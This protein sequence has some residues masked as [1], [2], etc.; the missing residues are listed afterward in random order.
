[1]VVLAC[2]G[3]QPRVSVPSVLLR[4]LLVFPP[5]FSITAFWSPANSFGV[6][7]SLLVLDA[8]RG[9]LLE[10]DFF[11]FLIS[12][13]GLPDN[14]T[15]AALFRLGT[16]LRHLRRAKEPSALML[17]TDS[18]MGR[19]L[20]LGSLSI[21]LMTT[22]TLRRQFGVEVGTGKEA[23]GGGQAPVKKKRGGQRVSSIPGSKGRRISEIA[24]RQADQRSRTVSRGPWTQGSVLSSPCFVPSPALRVPFLIFPGAGDLCTSVPESVF[25]R[26]CY[27]DVVVDWREGK[28][29]RDSVP[30]LGRRL[31]LVVALRVCSQDSFV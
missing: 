31:G 2:R 8:L 4:F 1:L 6:C 9:S 14:S 3:P 28:V 23:P 13:R 15:S 18:V 10:S 22:T 30:L 20:V 16:T 17:S 24:S 12:R 27:R 29:G 7:S 19:G 21:I 11:N 25:I 5:G 26:R